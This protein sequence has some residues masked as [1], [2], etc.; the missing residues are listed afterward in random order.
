M[1]SRGLQAQNVRDQ[2]GYGLEWE[3]SWE[4][5]RDLRLN[6][7][8]AWQRSEDS[9]SGQ[10]IADAPQQQ[11][12]LSTF[13]KI[14]PQWLLSSQINWVADRKR[15]ANDTRSDIDDYTLVDLTLKR[16]NLYKSLD[17]GIGVRNV[18]DEDAR[19]PSDGIIQND[20]PLEGRSVW[21]E[22][23]YQF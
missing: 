2:D 16:Q 21:M 7:S 4:I 6:S 8:Y 19:E 22:L 13:W 20:F 18:F 15:T 10:E 11:L 14:A 1:Y 5:T 3:A 23:R 9:D 12:T 17:I